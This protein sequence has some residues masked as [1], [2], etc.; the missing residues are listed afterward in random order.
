MDGMESFQT[1]RHVMD[2]LIH[3]DVFK[4]LALV[5][6]DYCGMFVRFKS[7]DKALLTKCTNN[8]NNS[9]FL[10]WVYFGYL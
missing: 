6:M 5:I 7:T 3:H 1:L 10:G 9:T 4:Q 8:N 2:L